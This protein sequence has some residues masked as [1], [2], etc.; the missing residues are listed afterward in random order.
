[1]RDFQYVNI[2]FGAGILLKV[3]FWANSRRFTSLFHF[4]LPEGYLLVK[5]FGIFS[6]LLDGI[7][8]E[9]NKIVRRSIVKLTKSSK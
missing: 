1:M 2:V 4:R 7:N 9:K 8:V 3:I 6:F 5:V